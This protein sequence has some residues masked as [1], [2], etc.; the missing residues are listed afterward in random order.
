MIEKALK[1][2]MNEMRKLRPLA[3]AHRTK[4]GLHVKRLHGRSIGALKESLKS[5]RHGESS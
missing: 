4:R 5:I 2:V 1:E 3:L